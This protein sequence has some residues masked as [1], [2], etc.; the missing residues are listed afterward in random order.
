MQKKLGAG[1]GNGSSCSNSRCFVNAEKRLQPI[2]S[3]PVRLSVP[4]LTTRC[5]CPPSMP[6]RCRLGGRGGSRG[7]RVAAGAHT[8]MPLVH[9]KPPAA[10][11]QPPLF[12]LR[13]RGPA[14]PAQLAFQYAHELPPGGRWGRPGTH[15]AAGEGTKCAPR[16]YLGAPNRVAQATTGR[17]F[18][19][20]RGRGCLTGRAGGLLGGCTGQARGVGAGQLIHAP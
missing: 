7:A 5:S 17:H 20:R 14:N 10:R 11:F 3:P 8:K 1:G 6:L 19:H 12:G 4:G 16:C 9:R 18:R 2:F 13:H 15:V